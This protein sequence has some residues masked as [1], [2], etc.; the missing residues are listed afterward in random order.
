MTLRLNGATAGFT[1]IDAPAVAGSNTLVLPTGAG[2]ANQFL[3]NG[4]TAGSLGWSSLVEDSAGRCGI[5]TSSPNSV[6][7]IEAPEGTAQLT[8]GNTAL[9][10]SDG[11]FLAGIDFHIKDNNDATGAVCTSI[12]S[13]ANQNHTLTAKG[14]ALAFST[15]T[16]D[17]TTLTERLRIDQAGLVGIGTTPAYPLH[18][19]GSTDNIQLAGTDNTNSGWR[20]AT[21]SSNVSAFG[22]LDGHSTAFGTFDGSNVFSE[23]ARLDASGRLLVGTTTAF[24]GSGIT[25]KVTISNTAGIGLIAIGNVDSGIVTQP[26]ANTNYYPGFFLNSSSSGIG[27]IF[28]TSS[29]TAYNTSSDYRLKENVVAVTDGIS[30]LL[31]LKPSR[32]NFIVDP[33]HTVDGFIAHEVQAVVPE[34]I[35]GTK[36]EV[37]DDGNPVYQGIDQ[38]K[39]VP[40]LT[41]ALQEAIAKIE[42]LEAR[43]T[44]LEVTP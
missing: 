13:I 5:G 40:L 22:A 34:A 41:A 37:D 33:D 15:T 43:L 44:A 12:R 27:N 26:A 14:T 9:A 4:S 23:K 20:I 10:A 25:P 42:S 8:I 29:S 7:H 17:T 21:P 31:Q 30:R 2:S 3:K 16:N 35:H 24:S 11:D 28:C 32:F 39:L 1:E 19:V 6:L 18:V 38:S 36:D